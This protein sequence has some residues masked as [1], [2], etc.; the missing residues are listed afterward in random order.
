MTVINI[1]KKTINNNLPGT[2]P[3]SNVIDSKFVDL[4]SKYL[5]ELLELRDRQLK[6]LK[7]K[8]FIEKLPDKGLKIHSLYNKIEN[9]IKLKQDEE[10]ACSL[11]SKMKLESIDKSS[12]QDIE[13]KGKVAYDNK[14][15]Y[16][17]SDDDSEPEDVFNILSQN[18][19]DK[20]I[21]KILNSQKPL[22]T[23]EDLINIEEVPHV[24][25]L[26]KITEENIK[27]K[28]HG[29]FKPYKTTISDVHK[30]E[31]EIQRKKH[32][33]WE[34][35]SATPPPIV[36]APAKVLSIKESLKLQR[37]YN[38]HLKDIETQHAAKKLFAKAGVKMPELP[39]DTSKFG[40][41]RSK[42][43]SDDSDGSESDTEGSDK[44]VLDEEPERGGVIFTVMK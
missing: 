25:Y 10:Q 26:V 30:P 18:T 40:E 43:D 4:S 20:K 6:L 29:Q 32:K 28:P 33:N 17:D 39:I 19:A 8:L 38:I 13:W 11:F 36:H 14:D 15:T 31:K 12:M 41:Y 23:T 24:K 2:L 42:M 1:M 3:S 7:N 16:L 9:E 21:V 34:I 22:I 44:E 37:E 5:P 35:T 27:L